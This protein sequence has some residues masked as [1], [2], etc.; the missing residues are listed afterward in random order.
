[1]KKFLLKILALF[2]LMI[3]IYTL[4]YNILLFIIKQ[5][6]SNSEIIIFGDSHTKEIEFQNSFNY[7]VRGGSY[8][9]HHNF[10]TQFSKEIKDKIILF[11]VSANNLANYK[12]YR[13]DNSEKNTAWIITINEQIDMFKFFTPKQYDGYDWREKKIFDF[14]VFKNLF[15]Y[16][17]Y[18][19]LITKK[20]TKK[21]ADPLKFNKTVQRHFEDSINEINDRTELLY[22]EKSLLELKSNNCTIFLYNSPKTDFYN[23]NI[24]EKFKNRL[25]QLYNKKNKSYFV[26]DYHNFQSSN[27]SIFRDADHLNYNGEKMMSEILY[28]DIKEFTE[29]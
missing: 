8:V 14:N 2:S 17:F 1:M 4:S 19:H 16:Y 5:E 13:F 18:N 25:Y 29:R 22:L 20:P 6:I 27:L 28:K 24:P 3:L 21:I 7:S 12:Q 10:I 15:E 11:S 23:S 26:L 9:L